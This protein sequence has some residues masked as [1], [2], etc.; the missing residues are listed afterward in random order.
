MERYVD[1]P[2]IAATT[3]VVVVVAPWTARV[4]VAAAPLQLPALP[5]LPLPGDAI[6]ELGHL[7]GRSP[8][9]GGGRGVPAT[10]PAIGGGR[11]G[12]AGGALPRWAKIDEV[13]VSVAHDALDRFTLVAARGEC[14]H[15]AGKYDTAEHALKRLVV[16]N[17]VVD[18]RHVDADERGLGVGEP[19][20]V[21]G[22]RDVQRTVVLGEVAGALRHLRDVAD[23]GGMGEDHAGV[24]VLLAPVSRLDDG[25]VGAVQFH[26]RQAGDGGSGFMDVVEDVLVDG[27][28]ALTSEEHDECEYDVLV[29]VIHDFPLL[30]LGDVREDPRASGDGVGH[31]SPGLR[32]GRTAVLE[33]GGSGLHAPVGVWWADGN[34]CQQGRFGGE[35]DRRARD[36]GDQCSAAQ[37]KGGGGR[38]GCCRLGL[39]LGGRDSGLGGVSVVHGV[40][41]VVNLHVHLVG[42]VAVFEGRYLVVVVVKG[43]FSGGVCA[44]GGAGQAASGAGV[45]DGLVVFKVNGS[46]GGDVEVGTRSVA[47]ADCGA[48]AGF[49]VAV[50]GTEGAVACFDDFARCRGRHGRGGESKSGR[51]W[52]VPPLLMVGLVVF[53]FQRSHRARHRGV[54]ASASDKL[55]GCA[56]PSA[57]TASV[58]SPLSRVR[59]WFSRSS[60]RHASVGT[61]QA[62]GPACSRLFPSPVGAIGGSLVGSG[63]GG[64]GGGVVVE[65][66]GLSLSYSWERKL[67][68]LMAVKQIFINCY[69]T[70]RRSS[71]VLP[72]LGAVLMGFSALNPVW[73]HMNV[74]GC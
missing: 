62:S 19:L 24:L 46:A 51:G 53:L 47:L 74:V 18:R 57:T 71:G 59:Y 10:S 8:P 54:S 73:V 50:W 43:R 9:F 37:Y 63:G 3:I 48:V 29:C 42:V 31:L 64:G 17:V 26:L 30:L 36:R 14:D 4:V 32:V 56:T 15:A 33:V 11:G 5:R 65:R 60:V 1:C 13:G 66:G 23:G 2:L 27:E 28:E 16:V 12:R 20:G 39:L 7:V 40:V 21:Y 35:H 38:Y 61:G 70:F 67:L 49:F 68:P 55:S 25:G 6:R 44:G 41:V 72:V 52:K 69:Y 45:R 58:G 34:E 22:L